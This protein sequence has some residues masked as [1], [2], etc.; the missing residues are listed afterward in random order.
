[1]VPLPHITRTSNIMENT[2]SFYVEGIRMLFR[3]WST[4]ER[5]NRLGFFSE[6]ILNVQSH[7]HRLYGLP[8]FS[9]LLSRKRS[10]YDNLLCFMS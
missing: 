9:F 5:E 2:F 4:G 3:S 10:H 8:P 7:R 6:S 1:M